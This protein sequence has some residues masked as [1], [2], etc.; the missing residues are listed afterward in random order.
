M[1]LGAS[2]GVVVHEVLPGDG[3]GLGSD[4]KR[5]LAETTQRSM[6]R[7]KGMGLLPAR[8]KTWRRLRLMRSQDAG[9]RSTQGEALIDERKQAAEAQQQVDAAGARQRCTW[10]D[11]RCRRRHLR[12][13]RAAG[14]AAHHEQREQELGEEAERYGTG[15]E[16]RRQR[17][18]LR[19]SSMRWV[20]M[21]TRGRRKGEAL[22]GGGG[23]RKRG[24]AP[25]SF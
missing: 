10:R 13:G 2:P 24:S 8:N 14:E 1:G 5:S 16:G 18:W 6:L 4:S 12:R 9:A 19:G 22:G 23:A 17:G 15:E 7:L 3:L 11:L 25:L 21:G 20:A